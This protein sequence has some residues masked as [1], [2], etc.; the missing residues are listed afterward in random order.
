MYFT[1][2]LLS[3]DDDFV[4]DEDDDD[5]DDD[6]RENNKKRRKTIDQAIVSYPLRPPNRPYATVRCKRISHKPIAGW[7][8]MKVPT[9]DDGVVVAKKKGGGKKGGKK[10]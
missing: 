1:P 8:E 3:Q 7:L 5:D 4:G 6:K 9:A 10:K 2:R